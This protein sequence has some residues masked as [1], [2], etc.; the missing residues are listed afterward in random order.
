[1]NDLQAN[2]AGSSHKIN[3]LR[4]IP[5]TRVVLN[6]NKMNHV[7]QNPG[8]FLCASPIPALTVSTRLSSPAGINTDVH[9]KPAEIIQNKQV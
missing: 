5:S 9:Q 4:E 7:T 8:Y 3:D 1:M 2:L 6:L